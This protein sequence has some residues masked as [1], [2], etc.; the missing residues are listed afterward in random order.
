M[1]VDPGAVGFGL[2]FESG[3]VSSGK[4]TTGMMDGGVVGVR[5]WMVWVVGAVASGRAAVVKDVWSR[6]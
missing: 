4:A 1:D 6:V 3:V 5:W 2:C